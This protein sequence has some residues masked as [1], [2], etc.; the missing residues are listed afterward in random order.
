MKEE[1][2]TTSLSLKVWLPLVYAI[3]ITGFY[4]I[5]VTLLRRITRYELLPG[6]NETFVRF[7]LAWPLV[8][9]TGLIYLSL[10][11]RRR[12]Y[13]AW[14][15]LVIMNSL[16]LLFSVQ[17]L[18]SGP[19][20]FTPTDVINLV[21]AL[22]LLSWLLY[23]REW[24]RARSNI[25]SWSQA[26]RRIG[27]VLAISMIYGVAGFLLIDNRDF[28]REITIWQSIAYT[29]DQFELVG[30]RQLHPYTL[31]ARLFLDSLAVVS[32]SSL[33]YVTVSLLGPLRFRLGS[34]HSRS[35]EVISLLEGHS[36][37]S[38]DFFKLWPKD[39]MY[40]F[41]AN[42][43]A[44]LAYHVVR[45]TALVLGDPIGSR[46]SF[47]R[48]LEEFDDFC[49]VNDWQ[50][51]WLHVKADLRELYQKCGYD[52]QKIG[53]E[54]VI[55]L[56][57][58]NDIIARN[59]QFRHIVNK[60]SKQGYKCDFLLPPHSDSLISAMKRVSDDWLEIPGRQERGFALG[61]FDEQYMQQCGVMVCRDDQQQ[62]VAFINSVPVY[63]ESKEA[64]YDLLRHYRDAPTNITDYLLVNFCSYLTA[65]GFEQLNLGLCPLAGLDE[66]S[67]SGV[68]NS[69]MQLLYAGGDRLYS[70]KGLYR[71]KSKYEPTWRSRYIA[72]RGGMSGF[73]RAINA[74]NRAMKK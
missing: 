50:P 65:Q 47:S 63:H 68:I 66:V 74:L 44:A 26:L 64:N 27:I 32:Y 19:L 36:E 67:D 70:F 35:S 53:A 41:A 39:K 52:L 7:S 40:F 56:D 22:G 30:N 20:K 15:L 73:T 51:A 49:M 37:D 45:G 72:Y 24:F 4:L 10:L 14:L 59:K 57:H 34:E 38:E 69:A 61:Y 5:A 6:A 71:Y 58:F 17:N 16:Y 60:F 13:S 8:I 42:H 18:L 31:Q 9:G 29:I 1:S 48:L 23:Q 55:K 12:K 54:A 62:I 28:H 43:K 21:I 11:L 46:R 3:R 2:K 25:A 33:I